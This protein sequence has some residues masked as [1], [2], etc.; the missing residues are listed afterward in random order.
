MIEEIEVTP[1]LMVEEV[2]TTSLMVEEVKTTSRSKTRR[3]KS[4]LT[5]LVII[6]QELSEPPTLPVV[7]NPC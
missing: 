3:L 2:K 5:N 4:R 7:T 6:K 1:S